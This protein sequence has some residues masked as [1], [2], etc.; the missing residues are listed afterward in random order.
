MDIL[1]ELFEMQDK[2]YAEFQSKLIPNINTDSIIGVRLPAL[3]DFAKQ[4][5]NMPDTNK[6]LESLP[7]K[8]YEENVLHGLIIELSKD[9][10]YCINLIDKFLPYVDNWAVCDTI[11]PKI[12]KKHKS[13]LLTKIDEWMHS[14]H[15]YTCRFGV[16]MLMAHFL[17]DDFKTEYLEKVSL[18]KSDEYYVNM[19]IAWY[20]AT[21]LAKQWSSAIT[22]IEDNRLP[23]W[24]HNKT[25]S[26]ACESYRITPEQKSYLRELKI[27]LN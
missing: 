13:E 14:K 21:A 8:Y 26:K 25:I 11:S 7:H 16:K 20:F 22:Y 27:K 24:T 15:T 2:D 18:I 1:K 19:M 6:F 5:V 10:T 3:R 12:F 23:K 4:C 9:Y 17:D